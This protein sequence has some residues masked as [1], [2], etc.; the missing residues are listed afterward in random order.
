MI[1]Q[2]AEAKATALSL[3]ADRPAPPDPDWWLVFGV[4]MASAVLAG[5]V[6]W[7]SWRGWRKPASFPVAK[8]GRMPLPGLDACWKFSDSWAANAT[9]VTAIFTGLFGAGDITTALLGDEADDVLLVGPV[10]AAVAVGLAG[11]SPMLL[12][13]LREDFAA[14]TEV[15]GQPLP[16][17]VSTG[18]LVTPRALCL[19][20]LFTLTATIGQLGVLVW[21]LMQTGFGHDLVFITAGAASVVLILWY[22][23]RAT[24]QNLTAGAS[25]PTSE[26]GTSVAVVERPSVRASTEATDRDVE[27]PIAGTPVVVRVVV[28]AAPTARERRPGGIL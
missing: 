22:G 27:G 8:D 26:D 12:Q 24:Q 3:L 11:L 1:R 2:P 16:D 5:S 4:F 25:L 14:V 10:A 9:V 21:A 7:R 13:G 19:A 28:A 20:A 15:K 17:D 18:I 6:L 23:Y